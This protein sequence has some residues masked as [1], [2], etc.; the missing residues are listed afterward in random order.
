METDI[1]TRMDIVVADCGSA[2]PFEIIDYLGA[3]IVPMQSRVIGYVRRLKGTNWVGINTTLP[4]HQQLLTAMHECGHLIKHINNAEFGVM[5][6]E[7]ALFTTR[8]GLHD[9]TLSTQEKEANLVA[10]DF[11]IPTDDILELIG[12]GNT[13]VDLYVEKQNALTDASQR[14][15]QL[16]SIYNCMS[17][18]AAQ[19]KRIIAYAKSVQK[20]QAE[21]SE[22]Q[23]EITDC[24]FCRSLDEISCSIGFDVD[25]VQ[26][27]LEAL[28]TRGYDLPDIE[29]K[30]YDKMFRW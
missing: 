15:L 28:K 10:A 11:I 1:L 22:L 21:L 25:F 17:T 4:E 29:L 24:G 6:Q 16:K 3:E 19:K 7:T 27:K 9:K 20:L 8:Q 12:Y 2:N 13:T 30:A 18:S 14:Y 23:R 26:Y 5:H